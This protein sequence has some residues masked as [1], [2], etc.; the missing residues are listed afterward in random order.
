MSLMSMMHGFFPSSMGLAPDPW[1]NIIGS[2]TKREWKAAIGTSCR[3]TCEPGARMA[4]LVI[5]AS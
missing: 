4:L 2:S 1:R 3:R 5:R